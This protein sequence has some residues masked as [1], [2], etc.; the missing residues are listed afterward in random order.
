MHIDEIELCVVRLPYRSPFRTSFGTESTKTAV[1]TTVRADG[2]EGYG[3]GAM[4]PLPLYRE[5]TI[6][7]ALHLLR[8]AFGPSLLAND[9][10]HPEHLVDG[11]RRWRGNPMAKTSLELAVWDL[12]A[13]QQDV[14]LRTLL[15]GERTE[16]P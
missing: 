7:G 2:M 15:G 6:T 11:W 14:P 1:L 3:E 16:I 4:E 13:R 5:E 12:Y 8:E 10:D 9:V